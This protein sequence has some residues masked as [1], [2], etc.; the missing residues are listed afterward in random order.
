MGTGLYHYALVCLV[1][2]QRG[3]QGAFDCFVFLLG[4]ITGYPSGAEFVWMLENRSSV[5]E[6]QS[7]DHAVPT[8][9]N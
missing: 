7:S 1:F 8:R 2:G 6:S 9:L 3:A 5:V 4:L